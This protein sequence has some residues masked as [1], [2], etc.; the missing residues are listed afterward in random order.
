MHVSGSDAVSPTTDCTV[1][2]AHGYVEF[3]S[4][5]R[6]RPS[7]SVSCQRSLYVVT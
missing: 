6:V 7:L 3:F 5:V 2:R 4:R 1:N